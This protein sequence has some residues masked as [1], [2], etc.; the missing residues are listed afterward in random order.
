ML[1]D[2]N[3]GRALVVLFHPDW[4][5]CV[6]VLNQEPLIE[7]MDG[8]QL[9]DERGAQVGHRRALK[10]PSDACSLVAQQSYGTVFNIVS[11]FLR[12]QHGA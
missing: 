6:S 11:T 1:V 3:A 10:Q 7:G 12:N 9:F 2:Q 4:W 5:Y 8:Q